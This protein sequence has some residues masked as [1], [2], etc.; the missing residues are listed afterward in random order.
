MKTDNGKVSTLGKKN[1]KK[2]NVMKQRRN[3]SVK[4][5]KNDATTKNVMSSQGKPDTVNK[6]TKKVDKGDVMI[7]MFKKNKK[8]KKNKKVATMKKKV[9]NQMF[10]GR[11]DNI[12]NPNLNIPHW[13]QEMKNHEYTGSSDRV[14]VVA[15]G[16]GNR[17]IF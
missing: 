2:Q 8:N 17:T 6:K 4:N 3:K 16:G 14:K 12:S 9:P 10:Q 15:P 11:L 13:Y 5:K 7:K 1:G